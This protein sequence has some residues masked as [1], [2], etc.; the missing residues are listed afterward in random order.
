MARFTESVVE[1]AAL[2][3]RDGAIAWEGAEEIN[4][5]Y[6][7]TAERPMTFRTMVEAAATEILRP[8]P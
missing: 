1:D 8:L 6:D 5:A 3:W 2:A 7:S 4:Y